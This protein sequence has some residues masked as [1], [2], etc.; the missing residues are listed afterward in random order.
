MPNRCIERQFCCLSL[1]LDSTLNRR[2]RLVQPTLLESLR[3][4]IEME[5]TTGQK[6]TG[7]VCAERGVHAASASKRQCGPEVFMCLVKLD[8]EAG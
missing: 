4:I 5:K 6:F 1:S 2:F 3:G 8:G 7:A